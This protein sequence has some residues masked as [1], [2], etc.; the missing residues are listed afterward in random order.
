MWH[1]NWSFV[2]LL[3]C[4]FELSSYVPRHA[5]A[6]AAHIHSPNKSH[7]YTKT[8]DNKYRMRTPQK[9]LFI[10]ARIPSS[11]SFLLVHHPPCR[12]RCVVNQLQHASEHLVRLFFQNLDACVS[13]SSIS[14]QEPSS[15]SFVP[16]F[17]RFSIQSPV[18]TSTT[19]TTLPSLS[20]P[21]TLPAIATASNGMP[22]ASSPG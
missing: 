20:L 10:P 9:S 6:A 11:F 5:A 2:R 7:Q 17:N 18:P 3:S 21:L 12:E 1:V 22:S 16:F 8:A 19:V 15:C 13:V 14:I 4:V